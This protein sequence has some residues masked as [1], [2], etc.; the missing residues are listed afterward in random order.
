[1]TG[2][3]QET[4]HERPRMETGSPYDRIAVVIN[5]YNQARF[6]AGALDS[7]LAQTRPAD[8]VIVVDDGS[9][10]RPEDVL[11]RYDQVRLI[12]QSNKGLAAARNTGLQAASGALI[13]FLDADDRLLPKALEAGLAALQAR[14]DCAFSVGG[15][16]RIDVDGKPIGNDVWPPASLDYHDLLHGNQIAMHATVMYFRERLLESGGFDVSLPRVEDYDVYLRLAQLHPIVVCRELVAE[17]RQH[18]A[19]MSNDARRMLMWVTKVHER[20]WP[21]ASKTPRLA[22]AWRQGQRTWRNYY[23]SRMEGG[24]AAVPGPASVDVGDLA[25]TSPISDEFGF[26]RGTPIDR[27]Y[28]EDFLRRN[29]VSIRGRVLEVGDDSYSRRFGADR[30]TR[31][32]VLFVAKGNPSATIIGDLSQKRVLPEAAFDCLILTQTLHLIYDMQAAVQEMY[33][34]LRPGGVALVTVPGITRIDRG[35]WGKEWYWS[36]TEVS[37]YRLFADVFGK[38]H[39][40]VE[41]DGNVYAATLFLQGLAAEE[42]D[43]E[44]L[45]EYDPCFP[46]TITIRAAK[47]PGWRELPRRAW[48]RLRSH[49]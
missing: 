5:V 46:V 36:L 43:P 39:V 29:R 42:A 20:Q 13:V 16:R 32:D 1:M 35:R 28:I 15:Y 22:E 24:R 47:S 9:D 6:L 11:D 31:Q 38:K 3:G 26:D 49:G 12:R 7:V 8:E 45:A 21:V 23:R 19:N 14:P 30:I 40:E 17:Y 18:D 27:V 4:A 10:D 2:E 34:A 44:K 37:A 25:R 41:S 33:R 48:R